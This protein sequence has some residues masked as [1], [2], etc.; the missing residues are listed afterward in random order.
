[1][2][3]NLF[4]KTTAL[5]LTDANY[6]KYSRQLKETLGYKD[7]SKATKLVGANITESQIEAIKVK[8]LVDK[9]KVETGT[10]TIKYGEREVCIDFDNLRVASTRTWNS[11]SKEW[12]LV[13]RAV[14]RYSLLQYV[15]DGKVQQEELVSNSVVLSILAEKL[16][17]TRAAYQADDLI[18]KVFGSIL[19]ESNT[20]GV[21]CVKHDIMG[22]RS[23]Y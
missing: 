16:S 7:V 3:I 1:M 13:W 4:S 5:I 19:I 20:Y 8:Y 15:G 17:K 23:K 9:T 21:A 22:E 18:A 12:E 14:R 2:T 11:V 10:R 6:E